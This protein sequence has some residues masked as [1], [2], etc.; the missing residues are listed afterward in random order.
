MKLRNAKNELYFN[1]PFLKFNRNRCNN[2]NVD[3]D[4][5][6]INDDDNNDNDD[7]ISLLN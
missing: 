2:R 7:D 1:P 5:D 3:N 4:D 6:N